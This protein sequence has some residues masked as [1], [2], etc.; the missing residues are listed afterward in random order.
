MHRPS[1]FFEET[2]S[3]NLMPSKGRLSVLDGH[4]RYQLYLACEAF[5]SETAFAKAFK[6]NSSSVNWAMNGR[7]PVRGAVLMAVVSWMLG[8]NEPIDGR[9]RLNARAYLRRTGVPS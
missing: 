5:G 2:S 6:V 9:T 1:G 3:H 7:Y 8:V 4:L